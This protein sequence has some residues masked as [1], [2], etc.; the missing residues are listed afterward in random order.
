MIQSNIKILQKV[1][2]VEDE[3]NIISYIYKYIA[4]MYFYDGLVN[5][6]CKC[7]MIISLK[8][9]KSSCDIGKEFRNR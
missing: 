9:I 8:G 1:L 3:V 2:T 7:V 5:E 4:V 6:K